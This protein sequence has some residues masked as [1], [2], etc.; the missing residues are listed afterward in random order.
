M[1]ELPPAVVKDSPVAAVVTP[2]QVSLYHRLLDLFLSQKRNLQNLSVL[3]FVNFLIAGVGF[4]TQVKIANTLGREN[5]GLLAYGLAIAA[6]GG[7]VIRFGLDRTLVRDLIHYPQRV[8]EL[9]A[10]SLVLRWVLFAFVVSALLAWRLAARAASDMSW[11]LLLVIVGNSMMSMDLQPVYDSW[12]AMSRHAVYNL[13][14]RSLYFAVIWAVIITEPARLGIPWIGVASMGSVICYLALQ[15]RWA[16]S[17]LSIP[18]SRGE[19]F[20]AAA[21]MAKGNLTVWLASVGVLSSAGLNQLILKHYHGAAELGGYAAAWQMVSLATMLLNQVAR[22]GNPLTAQITRDGVRSAERCRFLAKYACVMALTAA[23]VSLAAVCFPQTIMWTL[24][25]PEY[26]PAATVLRVLGA[27]MLVY[28]VGL[29]AS[30]FVV[31]TRLEKTYFVSVL[32]GGILSVVACLLFIPPLGA[33]GAG[34][35]LLISASAAVGLC[36]LAIARTTGTK[37]SAGRAGKSVST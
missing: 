7:V 28:A 20:R 2:L 34:L 29:V 27:Y 36:W 30:Q 9:V 10:A 1:L 6:Y 35:A 12:H 4:V 21:R 11:G 15:H 16:M 33:N 13:V 19:V 23:P 26:A 8:G 31:S 18:V 24:F 17:R 5:F 25:R 3:V 32:V 14:Q 22:I 37:A